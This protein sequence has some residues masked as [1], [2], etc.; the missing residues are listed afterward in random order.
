MNKKLNNT[1]A[2]KHGY[3]GKENPHKLS[4]VLGSMKCRCLNKSTSNYA[5]YGGR[6]IKICDEWL[7]DTG[8]FI[9]WAL[10]NGWEEG[11]HIDRIDNN[12]DYSPDN[13]RFVTQGEN[14]KNQRKRKDNKSGYRGVSEQR[15]KW[16]VKVCGCY[17]GIFDC[18]IDAAIARDSYI[19]E[20][21]LGLPLNFNRAPDEPAQK[22]FIKSLDEIP[23]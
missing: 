6:G 4:S 19:I 12:G 20:H 23:F 5:D 21:D 13:C 15:G 10:S 18:P 16:Q 2:R 1:N 22:A 8:S 11:L 7:L 3:S 9:E 14:N 17:V